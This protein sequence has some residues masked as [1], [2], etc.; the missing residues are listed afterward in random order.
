MGSGHNFSGKLCMVGS[1]SWYSNEGNLLNLD[2]FLKRNYAM[3]PTVTSLISGTLESVSSPNDLKYFEPVSFLVFGSVSNYKYTLVF[4]EFDSEYSGGISIPQNHSLGLRSREFCSTLGRG[5]NVF[6]LN[7]MN[8][9]QNHTPLGQAINYLP[10]VMS[11]NIIQCYED[12]RKVLSLRYPAFWSIQNRNSI[13]GKIWTNKTV[14]ESGYFNRSTF[15][16]DDNIMLGVSGLRYRYTVINRV[17]NLCLIKKPFKREEKYPKGN[18]Y[19]MRFDMSVRDSMGNFFGVMQ[20]RSLWGDQSY[21]QYPL[22]LSI[23]EVEAKSSYGGRPFNISFKISITSICFYY[24]NLG[25]DIQKST[26]DPMDCNILLRFQFP[27]TNAK[28]GGSQKIHM[29]LEITVV[30]ISNTLACVFVGLQL[31]YMKKNPQV[32]PFVSVVMLVIL[33]LGHAIPLVLNFE[34][35][36]LGSRN[37]QNVLLRIGGWP[38]G[39]EVVV[40]VVTMVAFL[41]EFRLLQLAFSARLGDENQKGLSIAEKRRLFVIYS[42]QRVGGRFVVLQR[43]SEV[44]VYEMVNVES[45]AQSPEAH[46]KPKLVEVASARH[47]RWL[48]YFETRT[49][50]RSSGFHATLAP[51]GSSSVCALSGY[52][53]PMRLQEFRGLKIRSRYLNRFPVWDVGH[54]DCLRGGDRKAWDA[55]APITDTNWQSF[56]LQADCAVLVEF[57]APWCGP[58]RMIHPVIDELAKQYLG[59]LKCCKVNT[60][61][62]PS[63]ATR[64]GIRSIPTVMIFKDGEKKDTVIGAVPKSMLTSSIEKFFVEVLSLVL[65]PKWICLFVSS[66][67]SLMM[68]LSSDLLLNKLHVLLYSLLAA[69]VL[70]CCLS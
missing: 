18:S 43:L 26:G 15:G 37:R 8:D 21:E 44:E 20:F 45:K 17:K 35:L 65:I 33:I 66:L 50:P 64:Y 69:A 70:Y 68:P 60:D 56:V 7:Y 52:R 6:K 47:I 38:E 46:Q 3:H 22:N 58:C 49:V 12:E 53:K 11:L 57:W 67:C 9:L 23:S 31:F 40:R 51:I 24:F 13:F 54:M 63:I 62:S 32:L 55:V 30:V 10:R 14:N 61:E 29:D 36:F 34:A 2:A 4:G 1:A 5:I 42:Q 27:S 28:K 41:L 48:V 59:K 19:V 25:P 39:N 16:S